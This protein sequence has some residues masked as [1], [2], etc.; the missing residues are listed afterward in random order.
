V[1][2]LLLRPWFIRSEAESPS[3]AV[4]T[5]HMETWTTQSTVRVPDGQTV[6]LA[7]AS[8][9]ADA[10]KRVLLLTPHVLRLHGRK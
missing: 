2:R 3:P 8:R 4:R 1:G 7:Q 6:V 10:K 9:A 5:P